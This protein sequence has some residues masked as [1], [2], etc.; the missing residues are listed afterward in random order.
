MQKKTIRAI[1]K[2]GRLYNEETKRRII[3]KE[4]ASILLEVGEEDIQEEDPNLNIEH[5]VYSS[6]QLAR[7]IYKELGLT[8]MDFWLLKPKDSFFFFKINGKL[9]EMDGR[10]RRFSLEFRL[11]ILEDLYLKH[12]PSN[13]QP[14]NLCDCY[15]VIDHCYSEFQ[16][17]EPIY[18]KSLNEART[19]IHALYFSVVAN[20]A[21]NVFRD[22][23]TE[24]FYE[25]PYKLDE[26]RSKTM[27][28]TPLNENYR[29]K[30]FPSEK[31]HE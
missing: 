11:Q 29:K 5:E 12:Q 13:K 6:D 27:L 23:Y 14:P 9:T 30:F 24:R 15:C 22:F 17:F 3:I 1:S 10:E 21:A 8:N 19:R 20:P 31:K 28:T 26:L 4:N 7:K 18:A 2:F 25:K 16:F